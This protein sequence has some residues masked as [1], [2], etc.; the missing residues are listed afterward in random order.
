MN[1]K[2]RILWLTVTRYWFE[3]IE[4]GEKTNDYREIKAYWTKRLFNSDGS[5]KVYDIVKVRLGYQ[6][7]APILTRTWIDTRV[8][9][10][11]D[12]GNFSQFGIV[13]GR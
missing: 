8:F 7:N 9:P 10:S 2:Q 1:K 6:K 3:K 13:M 5:V 12:L 4:S 11:G